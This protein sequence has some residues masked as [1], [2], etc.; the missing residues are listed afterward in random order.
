VASRAPFVRL[1]GQLESQSA[2]PNL[3]RFRFGSGTAGASKEVRVEM[4]AAYGGGMPATWDITIPDMSAAGGFDPAWM[5]GTG[6][7][8]YH[9]IAFAGKPEMLFGV[10]PTLIGTGVGV[11][12]VAGDAIAEGFRAGQI[13]VSATSVVGGALR[14]S[15]PTSTALGARRVPAQ[16]LR[17]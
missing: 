9:S 10:N 7:V 4:T 2:F 3:V 17:R 12:P 13:T 11:L 5:L 15:A 14:G 1:R 8:V 6:S 16:Y